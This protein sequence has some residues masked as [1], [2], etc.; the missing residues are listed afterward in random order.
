MGKRWQ[1]YDDPTHIAL[2]GLSVWSGKMKMAG[3]EITEYG[4]TGLSGIPLFNRMPF[5]LIHW[6]PSFLFGYF[7]WNLG[8]AC[9]CT[10]VRRAALGSPSN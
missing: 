1:G 4:T 6:I 8:E 7:S 3:F 9:V 10:G 5:G 2:N